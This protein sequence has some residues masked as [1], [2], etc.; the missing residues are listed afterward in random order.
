M[1]L[2]EIERHVNLMRKNEDDYYFEHRQWLIDYLFEKETNVLKMID[3]IRAADAL[4]SSCDSAATY[5]ETSNICE[6][7]CSPEINFH[8]PE[9]GIQQEFR[10]AL[11]KYRQLSE[12]K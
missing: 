8:E 9:C 3:R 4:A 1:N 11:E 6:N 10:S 2:T 7:N 5:Y 12:E